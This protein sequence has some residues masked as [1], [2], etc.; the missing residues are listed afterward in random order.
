M[1][2]SFGAVLGML[3]GTEQSIEFLKRFHPHGLWTLT[4]IQP[5]RKAIET[6]TFTSDNADAAQA[7]VSK[8][9]G[10]RNIYFSANQ[11]KEPVKKKADK[12]DMGRAVVLH[13]DLDCRAGEALEAE[14]ERLRLLVEE[15]ENW[16]VAIPRPQVAVFSGGGYQCFWMLDKHVEIGGDLDLA[17]DFERYNKALELTLGADNCHNVDR[18][19]RLP[20]TLNIPDEKKM[21]KGR[22]PVEARLVF[23]EE[24]TVELSQFTPAPKVQTP[25]TAFGGATP[26]VNISGNVERIDDINVLDEWGVKDSV[27]VIIVQGRTPDPEDWTEKQKNFS[28]SE[29]CFYAVCALARCQVPDDIIFSIITDPQFSI[30]E[31]VL[32]QKN[33]EKYAIR[34]IE[35]AKEWVIEPMLRQLNER[36]ALVKNLGGKAMI[37]EELYDEIARRSRLTKMS[38]ANF[39]IA[40]M[41][42]LVQIGTKD[43]GTPVYK[44]AGKFWLE[45]PL[46]REYDRL[47]F[48]PGHDVPGAYNLWQ[49]F[50]FEAREGDC[51]LILK[52]ILD[53]V[54]NGIEEHNEYLL[55][56]MARAVQH[57][58][59]SGQSAV[60]LR[61][62][63]GT[64]KSFFVKT[65]GELFGRH[66]L[67]VSDAKH[68]VGSFNAHLRDCVVLFG[69]EAFYAGDRKHESVL[70]T[71]VTEEVLHYEAKGVDSEQGPNY[72][73]LLMASN[74]D[75]VVPADMDDRR[76]FVLDVSNAQAKNS[77]YFGAI[78]KQLDTGGYEALL[79]FL[80]HRDIE[81]FQVRDVPKTDALRDQKTLSLEPVEEWWYNKLRDGSLLEGDD[82]WTS[83]VRCD[84]LI[85]DYLNYTKDFGF[86]RRGNATLLGHFF[87]KVNP[88]VYPLRKKVMCTVEV[89]HEN[90]FVTKSKQRKYHYMFPSLQEAREHWEGLFGTEMDWPQLEPVQEDMDE[91]ENVPF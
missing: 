46:R 2:D 43:N 8:Y 91:E 28:R 72:V 51:S 47:V 12:G 79:H 44:P 74:N 20:G 41:N 15:G 86:T 25:D 26:K 87:N 57:P 83:K 53:N 42:R 37:V 5:D 76:F 64:G 4:S 66:F 81:N 27:K 36:Y 90:G 17:T 30:S 50:G 23:F 75:W 62:R 45:H 33:V 31:H 67:Q 61:G 49:G 21:K 22:T 14:L 13:V 29:W 55:N 32:H 39:N 89:P 60:I 34:Q 78:A 70:K 7:W 84:L 18:I 6:R 58:N 1:D 10:K 9:N 35:R 56:W 59:K 73:H 80:L 85:D 69:D 82:G 40:W 24:G 11:P 88:G 48:A 19:M 52:H 63:Q 3:T 16:P 38:A 71:L 68:L 54:C 65:F 77:E